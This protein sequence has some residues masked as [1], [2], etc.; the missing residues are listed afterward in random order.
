MTAGDLS[1]QTARWPTAL[2]E[3]LDVVELALK[4]CERDDAN[5]TQDARAVVIAI[6]FTFGGRP[7]YLPRGDA[8]RRAIRDA[9]IFQRANR[10]NIPE[11]AR[12]FSLSLQSIYNVIRRQRKLRGEIRRSVQQ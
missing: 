6:S 9:E 5:V 2:V 12:E 1:R 10:N 7:F 3:L 4:K 8:F 11:L